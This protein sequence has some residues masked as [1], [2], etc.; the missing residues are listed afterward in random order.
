MGYLRL[1]PLEISSSHR[2]RE[3]SYL[4]SGLLVRVLHLDSVQLLFEN[5]SKIEKI[6]ANICHLLQLV[7]LVCIDLG[8]IS[9]SSIIFNTG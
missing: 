7:I 5:V 9:Y 2:L 6:V 1:V 8:L 3:L 4:A